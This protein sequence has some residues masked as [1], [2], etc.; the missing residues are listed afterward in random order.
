MSEINNTIGEDNDAVDLIGRKPLFVEF[1]WI[2]P[3]ER[4]GAFLS[5][6]GAAMAVFEKRRWKAAVEDADSFCNTI[7]NDKDNGNGEGGV[8]A[9]RDCGI[10]PFVE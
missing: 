6:D 8:I 10:V 7:N 5:N 3:A 4:L 2:E 9:S 1:R